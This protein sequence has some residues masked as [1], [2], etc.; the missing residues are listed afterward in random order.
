MSKNG[1]YIAK[2]RWTFCMS[3][4]GLYI[5]NFS[6]FNFDAIFSKDSSPQYRCHCYYQQGYLQ[7]LKSD[8]NTKMQ[9]CLKTVWWQ[10]F[11]SVFVPN[12]PNIRF[13]LKCQTYTETSERGTKRVVGKVHRV[14]KGVLRWLTKTRLIPKLF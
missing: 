11:F 13:W 10:I 2:W 4:K 8:G 5:R 14:V 12:S 3:K 1:L 9:W 7:S 6:I